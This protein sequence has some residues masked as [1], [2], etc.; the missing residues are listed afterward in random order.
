MSAVFAVVLAAA[1][2]SSCAYETAPFLQQD[3]QT[4]DQTD[5]GWRGLARKDCFVEAAELIA[6]YHAALAGDLDAR[7]RSGLDWHEG[8]MRAFAGE[9]EAA[10]ELF[11]RTREGRNAVMEAY[12]DATLA[13][14]EGDRAGL[15][16]ARERLLAVPEPEGFAASIATFRERFPDHDPPVWPVNLHLVDRLRACFGES[17]AIAYSGEC[18][19]ARAVEEGD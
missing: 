17:Y 2:Q 9:T 15:E 18:D 16:A 12:L 4:F 11:E 14:L 1:L 6:V 5:E 13:F 8:Q 19:A 10:I 7:E 3:F